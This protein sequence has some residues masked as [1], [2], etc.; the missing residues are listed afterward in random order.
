M[1]DHITNTKTRG[2]KYKMTYVR[3]NI[4]T[5][6]HPRFF[7]FYPCKCLARYARSPIITITIIHY[8]NNYY[9]YYYYCYRY[10]CYFIFYFFI[11]VII[12]VVIIVVIII[13]INNHTDILAATWSSWL[14]WSSC[15]RTCQGG[16]RQRS[17]L[18][19]NGNT[20]PGASVVS[21]PCNSHITCA[22]TRKSHV[23]GYYI[24]FYVIDI[25]VHS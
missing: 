17:R 6:K 2:S 4:Y 8:N 20:C 24:L 13:I 15:S 14:T 18:C 25:L 11:V 9:Y 1:V 16:F 22:S 3:P 5:N 21:E 23:C 12:I 7:H 19:E 10:Y